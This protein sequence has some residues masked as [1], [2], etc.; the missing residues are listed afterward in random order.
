[1]NISHTFRASA[2]A[3]ALGAA[4]LPATASNA[5]KDEA[6]A[7]VKKGIAFIKA[8]CEANQVLNN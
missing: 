3:L 5:S 6:Q 8:K 2:L 7:M 4:L 1:M